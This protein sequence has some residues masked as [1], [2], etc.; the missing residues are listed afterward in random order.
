MEKCVVK[1]AGQVSFLK[2]SEI[3]WIDRR[4]ITTLACMGG[5][6]D[7]SVAAQYGAS[8]MRSCDQTV[9]CRIHRSSYRHGLDR[10]AG[11]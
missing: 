6:E 10:V 4:R 7:A 9:F 1:S 8:L 3:D 5:G 2:A 11:G